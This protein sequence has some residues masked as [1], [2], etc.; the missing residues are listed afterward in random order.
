MH[1]ARLIVVLVLL[2][3]AGCS[4][5]IH[6]DCIGSSGCGYQSVAVSPQDLTVSG[7]DELRAA[8]G[9]GR[10]LIAPSTVG[11]NDQ[12]R[13][14]QLFVL[15]LWF[16]AAAPRYKVSMRITGYDGPADFSSEANGRLGYDPANGA[17]VAVDVYLVPSPDRM[18]IPAQIAASV[19]PDQL[20]GSLQVDI[21]DR[22]IAGTWRCILDHSPA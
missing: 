21:A 5:P 13:H 3:P 9:R 22:S 1:M 6:Y 16:P 17:I 8:D 20:S 19:Q 11:I 12:V 7:A 2:L 4:G 15:D 14:V 10:C 18:G